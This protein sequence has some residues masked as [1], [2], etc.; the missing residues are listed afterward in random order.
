MNETIVVAVGLGWPSSGA[1]VARGLGWPDAE[2]PAEPIEP[3]IGMPTREA[4]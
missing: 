1:Q 3:S 2:L 4:Q